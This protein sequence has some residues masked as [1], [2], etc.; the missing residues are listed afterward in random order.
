MR[1]LIGTTMIAL[2]IAGVLQAQQPEKR[3]MTPPPPP[4]VKAARP[5]VGTAATPTQQSVPGER[6]LR[7]C[8]QPANAAQAERNAT[9]K[10]ALGRILPPPGIA[11]MQAGTPGQIVGN[12]AARNAQPC[13]RSDRAGTH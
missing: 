2:S 7:P 4:P 5:R 13:L 9:G 11:S 6:V 12:A 1:G 3:A 8:G 10:D